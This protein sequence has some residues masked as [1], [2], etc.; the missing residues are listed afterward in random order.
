MF[1]VA[2]VHKEKNPEHWNPTNHWGSSRENMSIWVPFEAHQVDDL[3]DS[4]YWNQKCDLD[5][6]VCAHGG[7]YCPLCTQDYN[8]VVIDK[9]FD[10]GQCKDCVVVH[11]REDF[12][13]RGIHDRDYLIVAEANGRPIIF[14]YIQRECYKTNEFIDEVEVHLH[15]INKWINIERV[16]KKEYID[17]TP[18][19]RKRLEE[20]YDRKIVAR[21]KKEAKEWEEY[22][23]HKEDS[24]NFPPPVTR[25]FIRN[26]K[27]DMEYAKYEDINWGEEK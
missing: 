17:E 23:K 5:E 6:P 19:T 14:V 2:Y 8:Q 18:E 20:E 4:P 22:T 1:N 11:T 24:K 25:Y 21:E 16:Y 13:L 3:Y 10:W 26:E 27:G 9:I 15:E 7:D 12:Q